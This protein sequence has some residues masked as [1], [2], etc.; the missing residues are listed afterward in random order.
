[1]ERAKLRISN[2]NTI[3]G[4]ESRPLLLSESS[5]AQS[6]KSLSWVAGKVS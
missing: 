5:D 4:T 3:Q 1:M 6:I 2:Q